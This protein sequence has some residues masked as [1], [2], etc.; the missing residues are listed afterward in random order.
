M[1]DS[2]KSWVKHY[3]FGTN[4]MERLENMIPSRGWDHLKFNR[5]LCWSPHTSKV[6][7]RLSRV[8]V[9]HHPH[10]HWLVWQGFYHFVYDDEDFDGESS[11]DDDDF[12][13]LD[14][15]YA[16]S[17][18]DWPALHQY[19]Q[20]QEMTPIPENDTECT[21]R[22]RAL[23]QELCVTVLINGQ[24]L[25]LTTGGGG[26]CGGNLLVDNGITFFPPRNYD[27]M[28]YRTQVAFYD[29]KSSEGRKP[30]FDLGIAKQ[31]QDWED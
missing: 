11:S 27:Y 28:E 18:M 6:F 15:T 22:I 7:V 14:L 17:D 2:G 24:E 5:G 25:L 31:F 16:I 9:G 4:D 12:S 8:V 29:V 23:V 3:N 26:G 30:R 13:K 19:Y 1:H 21:R 20:W 10:Q